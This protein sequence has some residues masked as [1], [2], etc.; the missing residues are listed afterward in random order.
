METPTWSHLTFTK[1]CKICGKK[2][3]ANAPNVGFCRTECWEINRW[4]W[5]R[6]H[7]L[8]KL[9]GID[10]V[11]Y[12]RMLKEQDG[13]CKICGASEPGGENENFCVDHNHKTQEV[14]GL[15]C[16]RCNSRLSVLD[17]VEWMEAAKAYLTRSS[18]RTAGCAGS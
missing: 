18:W 3:T 6:N 9:Y 12:R 16:N 10:E 8:K 17:D 5:K 1:W 7:N 2:F 13:R 15:L 11:E 4:L 14:R